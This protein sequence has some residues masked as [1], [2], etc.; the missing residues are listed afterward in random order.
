MELHCAVLFFSLSFMTGMEPEFHCRLFRRTLHDAR[1]ASSLR[2]DAGLMIP[3]S[4]QNRLPEMRKDP[5]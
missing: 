1:K 3:Y 2:E 5:A 4:R